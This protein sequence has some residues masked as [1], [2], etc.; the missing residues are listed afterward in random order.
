MELVSVGDTWVEDERDPISSIAKTLGSPGWVVQAAAWMSPRSAR[1]SLYIVYRDAVR[2]RP[3]GEIREWLAGRFGVPQREKSVDPAWFPE[4]PERT[5]PGIAAIVRLEYG[6]PYAAFVTS[7]DLTDQQMSLADVGRSRSASQVL[8]HDRRQELRHVGEYLWPGLIANVL[9]LGSPVLVL[10][11][12]VAFVRRTV[13]SMLA[14]FRV[15]RG[16]CGG[17]GYELSGAGSS[18]V[19]PE[20]GLDRVEGER[21]SRDPGAQ[22]TLFLAATAG[23][24]V[25]PW[26]RA[27]WWWPRRW[28]SGW[29][30]VGQVVLVTIKL[31][32]LTLVTLI[33]LGLLLDAS[34]PKSWL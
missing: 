34:I 17:C 9:I 29:L 19:C 30:R 14:W 25:W 11:V 2:V 6:W 16:F 32:A 18:G 4:P 31:L 20:C 5:A 7:T 28:G 8:W 21:R 23:M 33:V 13:P 22:L 24:L 27:L 3:Y 12:G 10:F 26:W 15:R 1:R